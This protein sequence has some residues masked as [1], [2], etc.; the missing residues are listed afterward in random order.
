MF[1]KFIASVATSFYLLNASIA[2]A[3]LIKQPAGF[4]VQPKGADGNAVLSGFITSAIGIIFVIGGIGV[5]FMVLWGAIQWIF[6]GGDKEGLQKAKQRITHALIGLAV[7]SLSF[8]IINLVGSL[9]GFNPLGNF[10]IPTF[11]GN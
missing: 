10:K 5:V 8:V 9:V 6:S 2:S 1:K 4:G 3:Q 7:L 11:N